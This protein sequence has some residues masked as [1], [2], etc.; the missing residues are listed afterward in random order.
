MR[1]RAAARRNRALRTGASMN[2]ILRVL[3]ILL[4]VL[5][6]A[7]AGAFAYA[8]MQTASRRARTWPDVKGSEVPVPWPLTDAEVA[9][10]REAK[11]AEAPP[12]DPASTEPA[13]EPM[14]GVDLTAIATERA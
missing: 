7:A 10:I 4:A 1:L 6:V 9:A 13:P 11:Q 2:R 5:L 8:S 3:G 14:A 12:V